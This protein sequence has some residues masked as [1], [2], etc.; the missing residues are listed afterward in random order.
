MTGDFDGDHQTDIAI[1]IKNRQSSEIG[2]LIIHRKNNALFILG[3]GNPI[4]MTRGR[5]FNW[6]DIWTLYPKGK[7]QQSPYEDYVP[8]LCGDALWVAKSESASAFIFWDGKKYG[9]YQETD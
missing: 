8:V 2:V 9:W 6:M 5:N 1:L 3:A 4:A 7:I